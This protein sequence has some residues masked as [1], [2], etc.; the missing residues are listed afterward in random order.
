MFSPRDRDLE[1][2]WPGRIDGDR[3]VQ[4]AAQTLQAFFTGGGNAREH[5]EYAFAEVDLRAPVLR[6]PS[7]RIFDE[8]R[9]FRF[10]NPAAIHGPE[11][12]VHLPAGVEEIRPVLRV[13][14]IIGAGTIG[15]FTLMNDWHAPG[16]AG[17]KAHDFAIS[18]GPLVVTPDLVENA[19]VDWDALLEHAERNTRLLPGDVIA[20]PGVPQNPVRADDVAELSLPPLGVLRNVVAPAHLTLPLG[21]TAWPLR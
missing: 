18:L 14:A 12:T 10:A 21:E 16:L 6:P 19:D 13:A 7:V 3:V 17:A 2:G 5:A 15:G 8:D 4:L 20:A 11:D 9:D 1:R